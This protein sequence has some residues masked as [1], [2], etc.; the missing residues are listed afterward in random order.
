M[1]YTCIICD[2]TFILSVTIDSKLDWHKK[3]QSI[4]QWPIKQSSWNV[5]V[6]LLIMIDLY[7]ITLGEMKKY[8]YS[9]NIV[10]SFY[11]WLAKGI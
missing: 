1:L 5:H 6:V 7:K 10:V 11:G 4:H 2:Y 8:H 9:I 3:V